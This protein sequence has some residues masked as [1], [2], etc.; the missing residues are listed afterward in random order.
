MGLKRG[1]RGREA[2]DFGREE[3]LE[4][5]VRREVNQRVRELVGQPEDREPVVHNRREKGRVSLSWVLA[6]PCW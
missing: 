2:R 1:E 4:D 6:C 5:L 3:G